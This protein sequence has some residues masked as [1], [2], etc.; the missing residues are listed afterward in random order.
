MK[1]N[2]TKLI[3]KIKIIKDWGI[4]IHKYFLPELKLEH[5]TITDMKVFL[6][7]HIIFQNHCCQFLCD[8]TYNED[9]KKI[10]NLTDSE[11]DMGGVEL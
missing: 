3:T 9:I 10:F 4:H 6:E 5:D 8:N 1:E 11:H 2:Y 7:T